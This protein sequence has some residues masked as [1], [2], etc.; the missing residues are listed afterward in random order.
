MGGL[1][2]PVPGQTNWGGQMN[3]NIR[4]LDQKINR[5]YSEVS[6]T[7]NLIGLGI[8]Y[9]QTKDG[10]KFVR[11]GYRTEPQE[12]FYLK[13]SDDP[14][15]EEGSVIYYYYQNPASAE[16]S[17]DA[18]DNYLGAIVSQGDDESTKDD[19]STGSVPIDGSDDTKST[20][21]ELF[22]NTTYTNGDILVRTSEFGSI[23]SENY[24]SVQFK[25][26]ILH[27]TYYYPSFD[28]GNPYKLTF[29]PID[30]VEMHNKAAETYTLPSIGYS[31]FNCIKYSLTNGSGSFTIDGEKA[32][33]WDVDTNTNIA[34]GSI[35]FSLGEFT[36]DINSV[37]PEITFYLET[38]DSNTLVALAYNLTKSLAGNIVTITVNVD[39]S[40]IENNETLSIYV[41][42]GHKEAAKST[43]SN[44]TGSETA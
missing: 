29:E 2:Y 33:G 23:L 13:Y 40:G 18:I 32:S 43:G 9:V 34:T 26:Y 16:N 15:F 22:G 44:A 27:Y 36:P 42:V 37:M 5:L 14:K 35:K 38:D 41:S 8:P 6:N 1:S 11:V 12:G 4:I 3:Q 31:T 20:K 24:L 28:R 17:F 7:R 19:E 39:V 25:K 21:E 10:H 30:A